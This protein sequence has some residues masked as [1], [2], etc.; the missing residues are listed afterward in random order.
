M[1]RVYG[2]LLLALLAATSGCR[3][4]DELAAQLRRELEAA[5]HELLAM[6]GMVSDLRKAQARAL[7]AKE[8]ELRQLADDF[9][10]LDHTAEAIR[11]L[12][13]E[14]AAY[15]SSYRQHSR[16]KA[17]GMEL[18]DVVLGTLTCR[19]ARVREVTDTHLALM[20]QSG[21]TR[22]PMAEAPPHLQD[23]FAYDPLLETVT[24]QTSGTGTDWLLSAMEAAQRHRSARAAEKS[25]AASGGLAAGN[26][27]A[28]ISASSKPALCQP[29]DMPA[30]RRFS[31]FTGSF[32][33]PLRQR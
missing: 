11:T 21:S 19:N 7:E 26:P 24:K 27:A 28:A 1:F 13:Q 31:N 3:R 2:W 25:L 16:E 33:A 15:K 8:A 10:Q 30:W 29:C 9:H 5:N 32:W 14:F 17:P 12:V 23:L 20:H 4:Q 6:R 22:I 18:G